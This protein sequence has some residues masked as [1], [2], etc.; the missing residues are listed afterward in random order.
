MIALSFKPML[1][2]WCR[3]A[4]IGY[5]ASFEFLIFEDEQVSDSTATRKIYYIYLRFRTFNFFGFRFW[6][7]TIHWFDKGLAIERFVFVEWRW[8]GANIFF[9]AV[10]CGWQCWWPGCCQWY[11][12]C[13][14]ARPVMGRWPFW[15]WPL[16]KR[17][18]TASYAGADWVCFAA[19]SPCRTASKPQRIIINATL[20]KAHRK[21]A[22]LLKR[23]RFPQPLPHKKQFELKTAY[24]LRSERKANMSAS[25]KRTDEWLQK[26]GSPV[27]N[28]AGYTGT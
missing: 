27:S 12:L 15:L 23:R 28:S 18:I 26:S 10:S 25:V 11:R 22:S 20:L 2:R 19:C 14:Q 21:A 7:F 24:S 3:D 4:K 16:V 5:K 1:F 17:S 6:C 13:Y 8:D 9:S